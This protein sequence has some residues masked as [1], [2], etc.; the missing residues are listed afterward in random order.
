[1]T[2]I[3]R[4]P[5]VADVVA[6]HVEE[7]AHLRHVRSVQVRA[8]HV[9]LRHLGRLDERIAAHLEG[10]AVA[11]DY[12]SAQALRHLERPG[13][14][15][16]F[17]AAVRAI[18]DRDARRLDRLI[19]LAEAL[20]DR[21]AGLLSAFGWVS[22]GRLSGI[23]K[24]LLESASSWW[25]EVG[26]ATCAMHGVDPERKL[27]EFINAAEASLRARSLRTAGCLGRI[28][29][30]E[31]CRAALGDPDRRCTFEAAR[32]ALLLGDRGVS[33]Q[34]LNGLVAD[35]EAYPG[36]R[37]AALLALARVSPPAEMR[38]LLA[39]LAKV[40]ALRRTLVRALAIVGDPHYLPWL[41][42]QMDDLNLTRLVGGA[43]SLITGVD[44]AYS[45]LERK[46]PSGTDFGPTDDAQDVSVAMDEDDGLPWPEPAEISAWWHSNS[47]RFAVGVRHFMGQPPSPSHC[48]HVL[49]NGF[50]PQR[51]VAAHHLCL[52]NPGT[53]LFNVCAP[54][55][56]Q[57]RQ[58][59]AMTA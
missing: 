5:P 42:T 17:V 23:T 2:P 6:Q 45:P 54:A 30:I 8:A 7:A 21:R 52:L 27:T 43:F 57:S 56:R 55:R 18:E 49:R 15:E 14:G 20:P 31:S 32:S 40:P 1:M 35:A 16:M 24:R 22:A 9:R 39:S 38:S 10:V 4:P 59:E 29:L 13:V 50:Q 41:I 3:V 58:L 48:L 11:G 53:P 34:A 12:G 47:L 44:L 36:M 33:T 19:A 51:A 26:I 25:R 46:P 28:D 37:E